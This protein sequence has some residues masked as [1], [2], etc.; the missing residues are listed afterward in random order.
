MSRDSEAAAVPPSGALEALRALARRVESNDPALRDFSFFRTPTDAE[1]GLLRAGVVQLAE[2]ALSTIDE[3]LVCLVPFETGVTADICAVIRNDLQS[4][5]DKLDG[6]E[7]RDTSAW[8]LGIRAVGTLARTARAAAAL[9]NHYCAEMGLERELSI[10]SGTEAALAI[11]RGYGKFRRSINS[12]ST[13]DAVEARLRRGA[14]AIARLIGSNIFLELR[15]HDRQILMSL[16]KRI[17]KWFASDRQSEDGQRL[18]QDLV[19]FGMLL[20]EINR[21]AELVEHD[22]RLLPELQSLVAQS[23]ADAQPLEDSF[24]LGRLRRLAGASDSIDRLLAEPSDASA[25]DVLKALGECEVELLG[26]NF[27]AASSAPAAGAA[28]MDAN[29]MPR[30]GSSQLTIQ[31]KET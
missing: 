2:A 9:E 8:D 28:A 20:R 26:Q 19:G 5:R 12:S 3:L 30:F 13:G 1:L 31:E 11:R 22:A 24:L 27:L 23:P 4:E 16:Q 25:A 17:R 14:T 18:V 10:A 21:R 6:H 15:A 29:R 7:E